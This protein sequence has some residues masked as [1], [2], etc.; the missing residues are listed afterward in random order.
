MFKSNRVFCIAVNWCMMSTRS[1]AKFVSSLSPDQ[2]TALEQVY[3]CGKTHRERQRAHAVLLSASGQS[4][5]QLALIFACD[6]DTISG[7]L[8]RFSRSG[9]EGLSDAPKSG[10][11]QTLDA[12]VQEHLQKMLQSPSPDLKRLVLD[13]LKKKTW[14]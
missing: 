5:D 13:D 8:G 2:R 7:W 6:R 3:R 14:F 9:I 1:A 11:P 12:A 4:L 10:R